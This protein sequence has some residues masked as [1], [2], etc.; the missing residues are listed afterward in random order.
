MIC[1]GKKETKYTFY[2]N[3]QSRKSYLSSDEVNV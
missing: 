1:T 3:T 2:Y